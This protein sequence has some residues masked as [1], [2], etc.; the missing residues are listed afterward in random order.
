MRASGHRQ[1]DK[2]DE[3][4]ERLCRLVRDLEL[5]ARGKRQRR[6][7]DDR[8]EGSASGGGRYWAKSNQFGSRQH[9]DHSCSQEYANRDSNSLEERRPRNAA[10]DAM[11]RALRRAARSPFSNNIDRAP[12]PSRFTRPPF[13]SYDGKMDLVEHISHYIQMMS[14]H[15]HNDALMY[16][17]FPSNLGST[18]LRWFNGLR[19]SSIHNFA[20]LIQ[21]FDVRFVTCS[22][23]PQP[24][25]AL[26]SM[27]MNV[28]ETLHSY[29]SWY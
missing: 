12:M 8:E 7:R 11:S 15:T 16:K 6:G 26:L 2:R 3:E 1:F 5:E 9:Q 10:M 18:A 28:G 17:V 22:W 20:E 23:V 24:V 19:K 29:A 14:L 25:D 13:N 21:E 4:L 27:K